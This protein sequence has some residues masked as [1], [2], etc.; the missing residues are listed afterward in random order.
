MS[1][2]RPGSHAPRGTGPWHCLVVVPAFNEGA[3]VAGVVRAV[4]TEGFPVLVV[5]D[6]SEDDTAAVAE[7]AGA[8]VVRLPANVGVGAALQCGFR[9]AVS[10]GYGVV[11]QCDADGQHRPHEIRTLLTKM[12]DS[13]AALVIGTRFTNPAAMRALPLARRTAM[14]VL[15]GIA[16]RRAGVRL[17]DASS[18]FR[19]IR[20]PLLGEFARD[21]PAEYLGDTVEAII[22]A[23]RAGHTVCDVQVA[24]DERQ[25]GRSSAST[26]AASWYVLR[27][28]AA[29]LLGAGTRGRDR[30]TAPRLLRREVGA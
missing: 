12:H 16:S 2:G 27:V 26:L 6:G 8:E 25:A 22:L 3:S 21:Y 20:T 30:G 29:I 10:H 11:V 28:L 1:S 7:A 23:G 4:L 13:G 9:F 18:G 19:A 14:R 5:D 15:A 24:M 17:T